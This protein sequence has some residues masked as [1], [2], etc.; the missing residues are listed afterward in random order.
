MAPTTTMKRIAGELGVSITTVSKV[1]NNRQDIGHATRARV[2]AKIAELG[3]QPNAVARSLTLR[4]TRTLGIV[5]PDLM[6]SFF[7]EIISGLEAVASA[8]GY[9]LLLCSSN[10]DAG[11]E[12]DELE[13]LRQRQVD[14]IVLASANAA[15]NTD[16][17][18]QLMTLGIQLVMI[19]RD[20]HAAVR[21][22]RVVTDD[23]MVGR[24]AAAH[25]AE[26]K[27][28]AIAHITGPSIVHAKRR[29]VG[30]RAALKDA[31]IKPRP[32]WMVRGGFMESDGYRAMKKLLALRPRVDGV[33]ASNDPAAIGAM[34]AIWDAGLRVPEDV[35]VIGAGDIA[36]GDLLRV[37]LSTVSWSR[38]DEGRRA[39]ELMVARLESDGDAKAQYRRVVIPPHLVVRRSSGGPAG[40]CV[41][42]RGDVTRILALVAAVTLLAA[43]AAP[44][45]L[46]RERPRVVRAADRYLGE[47][48]VTVTASHSPRSAGGP[49]DFFSE[50]DYWWP[51]PAN[52]DGPYVQ[53]DGMSNPANFDDHRKAL[54]RL[55]VQV[56]ALVA[57]WQLTHDRRYASRAADHLRAWFI[58]AATRMNPTLQYAQAIHGRV[59]GRGTGI[60][61]TIHL[62]EVARAIERLRDAPGWTAD[63][64]AA[65]R[66]WFREYTT[67]MTTHPYGIAERDAK[68]NHATCWAMQVAAFAHLTGD[69]ALMADVRTRF[70]T[71]LVP[72]QIAPDGSFPEELRRTKPYGYSLFNL[73]A[74]ATIAWILSTP[75]DNLWTFEDN[76]RG[77]ARAME[78]M[79][80]YISNK[81][82]WPKP[83][84]VMYDA[85]WPMRQ[86]S[87][88]FGGIALR[89]PEYVRLW[90]TLPADSNVEEV[91]RNFF[92]RQPVL[93]VD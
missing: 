21:C 70:K 56:P 13:L 72:K 39:G 23:E 16:L 64:D 44:I 79:V 31:G 87:L 29:A 17:L 33:F 75:E 3:Y 42:L 86:A 58:A 34:K 25:L 84:D 65:V 76:G 38:A 46:A 60:I 89:R 47:R 2:L 69:T 8:R 36:L 30:Y 62:V 32:E 14:G 82:A 55:S 22:D 45:D 61:D 10:E 11:K 27:R 66:D 92:I 57:A 41:M 59:T 68:N 40:A 91:I 19:D 1:L 51:D 83:P 81:P 73:E 4:R 50:G 63:D 88:L 18:K 85:E 20:D 53:R 7:V 77:L 15:G 54:M 12:R 9:G 90:E 67:W 5:I 74:M 24:L 52:P 37:P 6:H 71:I 78:F 26:G 35:A 80:P 48:P 93:W 28:R 43:S 49:H